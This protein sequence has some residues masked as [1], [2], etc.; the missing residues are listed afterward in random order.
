MRARDGI[1]IADTKLTM[2]SSVT[3]ALVEH[4]RPNVELSIQRFLMD[5]RIQSPVCF[6]KRIN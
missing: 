3:P 2:G 5:L 1:I 6:V 4:I